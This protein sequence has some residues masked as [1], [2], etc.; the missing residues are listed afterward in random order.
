MTDITTKTLRCQNGVIRQSRRLALEMSYVLPDNKPRIVSVTDTHV[1][2]AT[3]S[4]TVSGDIAELDISAEAQILYNAL[5]VSESEE[6]LFSTA[7]CFSKVFKESCQIELDQSDE[8]TAFDVDCHLDNVKC[9]LISDRKVVLTL[10]VTLDTTAKTCISTQ[11]VESFDHPNV[12]TKPASLCGVRSL[13]IFHTDAFIKEDA[14]LPEGLPQVES[15]LLRSISVII[16][17]SKILNGRAIF[18]GTL[19][20]DMVVST[21]DKSAKFASTCIDVS[22][23]QVC[24]VPGA[25]EDS[26]L[27]ITPNV[28]SASFD[29][30]SGN[31]VGVDVSVTFAVE[32][33]A[34][35]NDNIICDAIL[36]GKTL[37]PQLCTVF[38]CDSAIISQSIGV[39]S[40]KLTPADDAP[41]TVLSAFVTAQECNAYP[42]EGGVCFDGV[43]SVKT[44]YVP[45]SDSNLLCVEAHQVPF[46]YMASSPA[47]MTNVLSPRI[48]VKSVTAQANDFGEITV[49]WVATAEALCLCYTPADAISGAT[50]EDNAHHS[51]A[52]YYHFIKDGETAWD[53]A[54]RFAVDP[55]FICSTNEINS[56]TEPIEQKGVVV[57]IKGNLK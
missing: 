40:E 2:L 6:H 31:T 8:I 32:A 28:T 14:Q 49:K 46:S 53:V 20:A 45:K 33:F 48:D 12:I 41:Q 26:K 30:K 23:N 29:V 10:T 56:P 42:T 43:Y 3:S 35:Y 15:I 4:V 18:Y 52:M 22:F 51:P 39:C 50:V 37:L 19:H 47:D 17:N 24:D 5:A 27:F 1:S 36:P 13:G 16:D 9:V 7:C 21:E 38:N 57:I 25:G 34:P 54:R 11:C 55:V 44:V